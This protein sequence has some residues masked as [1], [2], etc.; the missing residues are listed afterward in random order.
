MDSV[1]TGFSPQ[2]NQSISRYK[3]ANSTIALDE[4]RVKQI[5]L[6]GKGIASNTISLEYI[7]L[8]VS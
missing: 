1:F 6:S 3:I 7:V 5:P 4:F 8:I 2:L